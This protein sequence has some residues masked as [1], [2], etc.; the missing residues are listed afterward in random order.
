M[1]FLVLKQANGNF[2]ELVTEPETELESIINYESISYAV[3][4]FGAEF[5]CFSACS[6]FV[7]HICTSLE[8]LVLIVAI[9]FPLIL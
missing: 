6:P 8:F 2:C 4:V 5:Y 9:D 3:L 1:L 7:L